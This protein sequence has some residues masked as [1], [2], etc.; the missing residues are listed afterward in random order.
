MVH[1]MF[2]QFD[3]DSIGD[4]TKQV[5]ERDQDHKLRTYEIAQQTLDILQHKLVKKKRRTSKKNVY[6]N[7]KLINFWTNRN[8]KL[9][10]FFIMLLYGFYNQKEAKKGDENHYAKV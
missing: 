2:P 3:S 4:D 1:R 9:T 6:C 10:S 5:I 8:S 7:L